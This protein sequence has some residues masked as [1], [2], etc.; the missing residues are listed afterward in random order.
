MNV[1]LDTHVLLWM[2]S[3]SRQ[4]SSIARDVLSNDAN[5][6]LF[7]VAAYWELGIKI[8]IG[9]LE[10]KEGWQE[11]LPKEIARNGISWLPVVPSH[12]HAVARLPWIHRDP[13]DRLLIAQ[14][15]TENLTIMTADPWFTDYGVP[16]VW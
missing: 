9:K 14:A 5:K 6:L 16:V 1:L 2:V 15:I 11:A 12:I 3:R 13:F 4:L 8:S 10:L 7:S